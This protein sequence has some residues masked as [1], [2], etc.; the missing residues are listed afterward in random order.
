MSNQSVNPL[1][2]LIYSLQYSFTVIHDSQMNLLRTNLLLIRVTLVSSGEL[3]K[4]FMCILLTLLMNSIS[5]M[6]CGLLNC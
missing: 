4:L 2:E 1:A 3:F 5:P 6:V